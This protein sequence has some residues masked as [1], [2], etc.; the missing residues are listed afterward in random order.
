M[1]PPRLSSF[2]KTRAIS[3]A[4]ATR[5]GTAPWAAPA[6]AKPG[7]DMATFVTETRSFV[8]LPLVVTAKH[9]NVH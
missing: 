1:Q 9:T 4:E 7:R 3:D 6:G 8:R 5:V 2:C